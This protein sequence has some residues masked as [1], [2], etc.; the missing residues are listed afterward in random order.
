MHN[1]HDRLQLQHGGKPA[2][3]FAVP[4]RLHQQLVLGAD[5]EHV[6]LA[7]IC[8]RG[9]SVFQGYYKDEAQTAEALDGDGW[10]HTGDI[11]MWIEGGRLKIFDRK[12][13]I[14]KLA[15]APPF[16]SLACPRSLASL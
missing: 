12:K 11:G 14:F 9:P 2:A 15:Q 1:W 5:V 10:L 8:V 16:P 13:N 3:A 7:Q 6:C 4:A